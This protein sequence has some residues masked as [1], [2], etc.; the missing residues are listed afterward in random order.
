MTRIEPDPVGAGRARADAAVAAGQLVETIRELEDRGVAGAVADAARALAEEPTL[1]QTLDR[2]VELAMVMVPGCESAGISLVSRGRIRSV[3]V[4]SPLVARGDA[5]QYDLGEGPCLDAIRE[6]TVV[7]SADVES[8]PRWPRWAPTAARELGVRSMLGVQLYTSDDAHGALNLY[9]TRTGAFGDE[10]H[11]LTTTFAAVAAAAIAAARTEEQLQ[12]AV[13]TRTLIGQAQG[14]IM[15]RYTLSE[16]RAFA[17][18][19]RVSQDSNVKL[20]DVARE[21]VDTRRIPGVEDPTGR[22]PA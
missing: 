21:I 18:M 9:S 8:D 5:L 11:H 7:E 6:A 13:R 3:A 14:I 15:E 17:V 19:S 16:A 4:S 2:V 1:Q 22:A 10:A 20:V 12:S